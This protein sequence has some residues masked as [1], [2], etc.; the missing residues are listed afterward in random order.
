MVI[1][2]H[3]FYIRYFLSFLLYFCKIYILQFNIY[4]CFRTSRNKNIFFSF[5]KKISGIQAAVRQNA[6]GQLFSKA[7]SPPLSLTLFTT[8]YL[9]KKLFLF[10][11]IFYSLPYFIF[12]RQTNPGQSLPY[13]R[14]CLSEYLPPQGPWKGLPKHMAR[15]DS[16]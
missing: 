2:L 6:R 1:I 11:F 15:N 3:G 9:I 13:L 8:P 14:L 12:L 5:A 4:L 7:T 10:P 16:N